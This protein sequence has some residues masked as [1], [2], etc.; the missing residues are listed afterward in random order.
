MK[1]SLLIIF[2]LLTLLAC[3]EEVKLTEPEIT[4]K[5]YSV[6]ENSANGTIVGSV[7]SETEVN[8]KLEYSILAGDPGDIFA[9]NPITGEI[10]VSKIEF[11]DYE[12][13]KKFELAVNIFDNKSNLTGASVVTINVSNEI[14][15]STDGLVA[16]YN[17]SS[18]SVGD[19]SGNGNHATN[20]NVTS[21]ADRFGA[22]NQ[23][24]LYNSTSDYLK[25]ANPSFLN[26][27]KGSFAGWVKFNS[28]NHTQYIGSVG[29]EGSIESYLSF[30]RLDGASKVLSI[31]QREV[32]LANWVE[33]ST[34][35]NPNQY[36]FIVM[37][38]DG[39]KWT[40]YINGVEEELVVRSGSNNGKWVGDLT[41]IDNFIIGS[42]LI[43]TPF[44]VP[45]FDGVID[46]IWVYSR[47]L[48]ECEIQALY[49][50]SKL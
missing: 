44:T 14:E 29:D 6:V 26:S 46:D 1:Y 42:L 38:S 5:E 39:T 48:K 45:N 27:T 41:S 36:Y 35:I 23:A 7:V 25:V 10:T 19:L 37:Q 22:V 18:G 20:L 3:E 17:F 15:F 16:Y 31:Y 12:T 33:G 4:N 43:K 32:G 21:N 9:I 13:I 30:I 34:V 47:P 11:L 49:L 28:V 50:D 24:T 8:E 40:L 2:A